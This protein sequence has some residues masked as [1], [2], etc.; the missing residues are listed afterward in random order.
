MAP[1]AQIKHPGND[2]EPYKCPNNCAVCHQKISNKKFIECDLCRALVHPKCSQAT[3][4]EYADLITTNSAVHACITC[5]AK[6]IEKREHS[7]IVHKEDSEMTVYGES[8][9]DKLVATIQALKG[10]T[11]AQHEVIS[12]LKDQNLSLQRQNKLL[13]QQVD[14]LLKK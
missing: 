14:E 6:T 2:V 13:H 12:T 1:V 11:G 8:S 5:V 10:Y 4:A 7:K 9:D 3:H